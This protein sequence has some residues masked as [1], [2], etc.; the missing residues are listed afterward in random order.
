MNELLILIHNPLVLIDAASSK[1]M[2]S[3]YPVIDYS[4][5]IHVVSPF[6]TT[7]Q[8]TFYLHQYAHVE[9]VYTA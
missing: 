9:Q 3:V 5:A 8:M 7:L 1:A 2:L 4:T 6:H